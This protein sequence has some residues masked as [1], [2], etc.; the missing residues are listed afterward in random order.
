MLKGTEVEINAGDVVTFLTAGGGGFG[1]PHERPRE[2]VKRD[3]AE[4]VI[5]VGAAAKDYG[6]VS[7][8]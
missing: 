1:D 6:V 5:S 2:A 3:I 7:D 4:G 8:V